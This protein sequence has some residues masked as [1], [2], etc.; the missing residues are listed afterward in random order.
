M[1]LEGSLPSHLRHL[2][3]R[4]TDVFNVLRRILVNAI[5][6]VTHHLEVIQDLLKKSCPF[7]LLGSLGNQLRRC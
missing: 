7:L 4:L 6:R 2:R 1:G 5:H 3:L